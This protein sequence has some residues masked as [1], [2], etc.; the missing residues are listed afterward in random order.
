MGHQMGT[1]LAACLHDEGTIRRPSRDSL[2]GKKILSLFLWAQSPEGEPRPKPR[3]CHPWLPADTAS[4][5]I[6]C[7]CVDT[8]PQQH[9]SSSVGGTVQGLGV[10]TSLVTAVPEGRA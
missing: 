10:H 1:W 9:K 7:G 3:G 6:P 5:S 2:K 4:S 8:M